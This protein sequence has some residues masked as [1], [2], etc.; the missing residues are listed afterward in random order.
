MRGL[1][2]VALAAAFGLLAACSST[3]TGKE[4]A[5]LTSFKAEKK[6]KKA[7]SRS[8]G[9]GQGD[10]F[11]RI[12]PVIDGDDIFVASA[13]GDVAVFKKETGKKVWKESYDLRISGGVG[14]GSA[15][16]FVGTADGEV[17]AIDRLSGDIVWKSFVN[18]EVLGAPAASSRVVVV[19][20]FAGDIFGL[21]IENGERV[22]VYN[23][24]PPRLTLRGTSSPV[25]VRG[26]ALVGLASG[27]L[28]AFDIDNGALLWDESISAPQGTTEI[29]RL[30][31]VDGRLLVSND[32]SMVVATG[33][34][35]NVVAINLGN[36][37]PMWAKEASS[38]VGPTAG[39]GYVY[40][41]LSDGSVTAFE[42]QGQGVRWSQSVLARRELTEPAAFSGTVAVADF[43]GYVHFL[44]QLDGRLVGRTRADSDGVRAPMLVDGKLLYVYGNS[45][46]LVAYKLQ[47][48]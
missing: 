2:I 41:A 42:D 24:Q 44:S 25:I 30:S 45:G 34:Q 48:R 43:E 16:V 12:T 14:V 46:K 18:A 1:R 35:G 47:D 6:V 22:W 15:M 5:E 26:V 19:Q 9:D 3:P 40:V 17:V 33:Y 23:T 10:A 13:D 4:P 21:N 28:A 7:W 29:E 36:G 38:Y 32:R 27:R 37:R 8:I 11:Y 39:L 31:D 20:T